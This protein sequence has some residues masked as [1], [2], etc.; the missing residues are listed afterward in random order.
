MD[1]SRCSFA[2]QRQ[3][4]LPISLLGPFDPVDQVSDLPRWLDVVRQ[5]SERALL[6]NHKDDHKG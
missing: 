2:I 4:D 5:I 6:V 1:S 3:S